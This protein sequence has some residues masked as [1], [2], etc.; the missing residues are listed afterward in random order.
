MVMASC[1]TLQLGASV[2]VRLFD[3]LGSWGTTVLRLGMAAA[4]VLLAARPAVR[5]WT[6]QQWLAVALFGLALVAGAFWAGYV[7]ISARVGKL[8][9]GLGGLGMAMLIA[10]ALLSSAIPYSLELSALRRLPESLFTVL[11]FLKP[12][13]AAFCG[14]LLL[15]RTSGPLRLAAMALVIVASAGA[16]LTGR[17]R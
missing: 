5:R 8:V 6:R 3:D 4:V 11:L 15:G 13:F 1:L 2:A 14:W 17:R 16:T 7:L 12:A 10:T 9:P